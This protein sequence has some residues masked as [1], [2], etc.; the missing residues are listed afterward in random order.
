MKMVNV[1][2]KVILLSVCMIALGCKKSRP[3][4]EQLFLDTLVSRPGNP[5]RV[6]SIR[7]FVTSAKGFLNE[8]SLIKKASKNWELT[9]GDVATFLEKFH[10]ENRFNVSD[11]TLEGAMFQGVIYDEI[12][13]ISTFRMTTNAQ[14]AT[15]VKGSGGTIWVVNASLVDFLEK[16]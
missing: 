2:S 12:G 14:G 16:R 4:Q 6:K 15:S 7:V 11:L 8:E 13:E 5:L 1:L 9:G 3:Y 10:Y